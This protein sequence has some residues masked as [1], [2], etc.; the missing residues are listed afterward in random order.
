MN[1][2]S[3]FVLRWDTDEQRL[4]GFDPDY[5]VRSRARTR[6]GLYAADY[7]PPLG[8]KPLDGRKH[9]TVV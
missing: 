3:P 6:I 9:I 7:A 8:D 2:A 5:G 4:D 1:K